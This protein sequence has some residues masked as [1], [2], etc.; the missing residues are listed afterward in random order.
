MSQISRRALIGGSSLAVAAGFPRLNPDFLFS[1]AYAQTASKPMV[2]LAAEALTGNWDPTTH[3]NLGQLILESF[4]FGYLTRCPMRPDN[5]EQLD[6]ELATAIKS[7]DKFTLEFKLRDGVTFHDGK[8]FGADDVKATY[9]YGSLPDRPAQWYPGQVEVEVVDRLTARIRTEKFGYPAAL[10]YY[11]SSFLP[12]LSAKDVQDKKLLAS[13]PN[14]TGAFKFVEQQGDATVLAANDK[15]FLGKPKIPG[16]TYKFVGD[17]TTRALELLSGGADIIERLEQEQ[18]D[19]IA[20]NPSF[21]IN[22]SVSVENKYLWFRCSKPPFNDVRL[23]QAAAHAIDRK[24]LLDV[25]GVSGMHAGCHISPVKF[26][27]TEVK[28]FP[29]FDPDK[30]QKLLAQAGFPNGKGLP[31]LEYYTSVGFY[32]KTK[33]YGEVIT[34]MLQAQG[35]P[36]KLTVLEVAAWGNL[37]YDR[38]GGGAGHMIDCGWCTGSPEPDLVLRTHFHSSSKRI[39]G[40]VDPEIDASLDRERN[41][42]TT[43]ERKKILQTDTLPLLAAKVP[44]LPLFTSVFIHAMN[45]K[46]QGI[47]IYPNGM[48]DVTKATLA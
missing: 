22:K 5:P 12:I 15:F 34:E 10:F 30:C 1:S 4:V 37:L 11:L 16:V 38:P 8:P 9:E 42:A 46:L 35:F 26:G 2:F 24:V 36:V 29:E 19:T 6:F 27:Y 7:I 33:E 39:T 17:T 14:G 45:K 21:V 23:R 28:D 31:D 47:Y 3:T 44:S 13:R 20:K 41:A 25:L 40:I 48:Q 32:P 18:V 43:D